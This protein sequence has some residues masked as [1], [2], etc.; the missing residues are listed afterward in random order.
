MVFLSPSKREKEEVGRAAATRTL[1]AQFDLEE[2]VKLHGFTVTL[3][4]DLLIIRSH[5]V[6]ITFSS[7]ELW[8]KKFDPLTPETNTTAI[9]LHV[10]LHVKLKKALRKK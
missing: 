10:K 8:I 7:L 9:L 4:F 1:C 3:T 6:P 2:F 5:R